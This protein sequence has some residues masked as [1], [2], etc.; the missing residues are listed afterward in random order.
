MKLKQ[1][2][3]VQSIKKNIFKKVLESQGESFSGDEFSHK[4]IPK[5]HEDIIETDKDLNKLYT[6]TICVFAYIR[7]CKREMLKDYIYNI[8]NFIEDSKDITDRNDN[9]L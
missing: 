2:S 5:Y 4:L 8:C 1:L 3:I 6:K 9:S 7:I